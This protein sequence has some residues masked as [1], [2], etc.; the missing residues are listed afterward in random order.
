MKKHTCLTI[1]IFIFFM[2]L[3][4]KLESALYV[5]AGKLISYNYGFKNLFDQFNYKSE[6]FSSCY[7]INFMAM[8]ESPKYNNL[9]V[10]LDLAMNI[11][12]SEVDV[13]DSI[14]ITV[15]PFYFNIGF[16]FNYDFDLGKNFHINPTTKFGFSFSSISLTDNNLNGTKTLDE[17]FGQAKPRIINLSGLG[18]YLFLGFNLEYVLDRTSL[19]LELGLVTS[20]VDPWR[21]GSYKLEDLSNYLYKGYIVNI[22]YKF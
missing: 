4:L 5:G 16:V 8:I 19:I 3:S 20:G 6:Q 2:S 18:G 11:P 10:G 12:T 22:Y 21:S 13:N 7:Q 1:I 17:L 14:S 15:L 9:W